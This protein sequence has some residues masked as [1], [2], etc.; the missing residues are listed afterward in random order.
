MESHTD[1]VI[2]VGVGAADTRMLTKWIVGTNQ[3]N[4]SAYADFHPEQESRI[5]PPSYT[6]FERWMGWLLAH[7]RA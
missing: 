3:R 2:V 6:L 7:T 4:S 1:Q 5:L